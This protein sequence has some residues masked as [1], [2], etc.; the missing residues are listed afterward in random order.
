MSNNSLYPAFIRIDYTSA[1]APH[2]MTIPTVP[3]E[4]SGGVAYFNPEGAPPSVTVQSQVDAYIAIIK[5]YFQ[6]STTFQSWQ[7]FTM[8]SP[9]SVPFPVASGGIAVAG[10]GA[11]V[12]GYDIK[13][14]QMTW[15]YRS[16]L[17]GV[18]KLIF[19]DATINGWD[20]ITN[21]ND[22]AVDPVNDYVLDVQTWMRARDNGA[23]GVFLQRAHTL[24][25]RLRRS[26]RMN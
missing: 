10:T 7:A 17:G 15:T 19:L 4:M 8:A 23:P 20:K 14:T 13:A 9:S 1:Y 18:F 26:Y 22:A 6:T 25:E 2:S 24:N 3:I 16:V 11:F 12:A 21:R 5:P